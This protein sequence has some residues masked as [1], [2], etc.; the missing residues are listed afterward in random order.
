M[1]ANFINWLVAN[2]VLV[3]TGFANPAWDDAAKS[4]I[5]GF[6]PGCDVHVVDA[7]EIWSWGGGVHCVTNGVPVPLPESSGS[8]MLIVY[9]LGS[10]TLVS[11]SEHLPADTCQ[12]LTNQDSTC[13]IA[14][15][16][17][18]GRR[19]VRSRRGRLI[20]GTSSCWPSRNGKL[21]RRTMNAAP[22]RGR[23]A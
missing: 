3:A 9:A 11:A 15:S 20:T 23:I 10:R 12:R 7:R 16:R 5:E 18:A 22:A 19:R 4:A 6:F 13:H 21:L 1:A 14:C 17:R 2:D 8:L